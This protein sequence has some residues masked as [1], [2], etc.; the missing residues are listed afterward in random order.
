M[1]FGLAEFARFKALFHFL[2]F[3]LTFTSHS[4]L[5]LS[6]FT[7]NFHFHFFISGFANSTLTRLSLPVSRPS[8]SLSQVVVSTSYCHGD[9]CFLLLTNFLRYLFKDGTC[10]VVCKHFITMN[11]FKSNLA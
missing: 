3:H 9:I 7:Y 2:F 8:F 4:S 1:N 11:R 10:L 5:S 6:M